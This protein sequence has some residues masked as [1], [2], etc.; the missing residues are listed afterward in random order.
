MGEYRYKH[1]RPTLT[2]DG[3][4]F[5]IH[6]DKLPALLI[7]R[8]REPLKNSWA[9]PDSFIELD[10]TLE[11]AARRELKEETSI[12]NVHLEQLH[13]YGDPEQ[14]PRD[15]VVTV[16]F[17]ALIPPDKVVDFRGGDDAA[18]VAWI[19]VD[20]LP[21]LAFDQTDIVSYAQSRLNYLLEYSDIGFKLLPHEFTLSDVQ[22]LYETILGIKIDKRNFRRRILI[23]DIIESTSKLRTGEGRPARLYR[24]KPDAITKVKSRR[25]FLLV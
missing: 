25:L 13:T 24:Y 2:V 20:N 9:L 23:A 17:L 14:D 21:A 7:K 15:R 8:K 6:H 1:S 5:S 10:E 19:P 11:E 4:S 22:R 12:E 18:H 3:V 16:A